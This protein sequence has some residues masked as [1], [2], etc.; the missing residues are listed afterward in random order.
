M[1]I[2]VTGASGQLGRLVVEALLKSTK[3]TKI[4][5]LVRD[6]SKVADFID[7][8]VIVRKADYDAPETLAAALEGVDRLLLISSSEVGQRTRQ[9]KAVIDAAKAA[10]VKLIAYTSIL[11]ADDSPLALAEEHRETEAYLKQTGVP[12]VL[13]RHGWYTENYMGAIPAAVENG[14]VYGCAGDGRFS[15][16]TRKDYAEADAAVL[17]K[18]GQ[19]GKVYELAGARGYTL[20]ELAAEIS[21]HADRVIPYVDIP[22]AAYSEALVKAGL[23]APFAV[24]LANSETG[25]SK[26]ALFTKSHDLTDL[27]GRSS[28]TLAESVAIAMQD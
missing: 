2:A 12:C 14:A 18:E 19:A 28:T 17:L 24:V 3:E 8:G 5:A 25:A 20:F 11:D 4:A 22:E 7:K 15:F 16:A 26:G 13:L 21:A 1:M 23:P 27:I 9:H 6:P 10:G